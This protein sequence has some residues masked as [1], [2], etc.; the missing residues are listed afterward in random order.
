MFDLRYH[1]ASLAAVFLALVI[2]ILVGVGLSGRGILDETERRR[3]NAEIARLQADLDAAREAIAGREDAEAAAEEFVET[4]YPVLVAERLEG[5]RIALL[6]VGSVSQTVD[7]AV[8]DAVG[9]AG[10]RIAVMRA[11]RTPLATEDVEAALAGDPELEEYAGEEQLSDLGRDLARELMDGGETPL[12]DALSD[13]L[14][15]QRFGSTSLDLDGVVVARPVE[16]Q[17][18]AAARFLAGFYAGLASRGRPA[19]G[20]EEAG[21]ELSSIP[22]FKRRGLSTVDAVETAPGRLAL[23]VLLAGGDPGHYGVRETAEDGILPP[24]EPLPV[25]G[26]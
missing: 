8:T 16:P 7:R 4:S 25:E 1:V 22:A 20:V 12:W 23:V 26:G 15:E 21:R 17:Q 2:G 11:L 14:V 3:L 10:G 5:A 18:G 6:F 9:D 19:V 13:E 24:I